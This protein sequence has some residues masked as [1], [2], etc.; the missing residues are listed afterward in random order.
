MPAQIDVLLPV[1]NTARY[2]RTSLESIRDQTFSDFRVLIIDDGSTDESRDI[3]AAF[4]A[5][6]SRFELIA[7]PHR[8]LVETLNHGLDLVTAPIVARQDA[9]DISV[10][11][12][13]AI[14][15]AFLEHNPDVCAVSGC[16][17]DMDRHGLPTSINRWPTRMPPADPF[18]IPAS[19]PYLS[20]PFL[21]LRTEAIR[22]ISGYRHIRHSEDADLYWRLTLYGRI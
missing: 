18:A 7:L 2:L 9:D 16:Y 20:H 12:R 14:E 19:E 22:A 6:D 3:A 11:G 1:Y 5:E 21:M 10:P 8:G 4:A 15:L 13:F 17:F